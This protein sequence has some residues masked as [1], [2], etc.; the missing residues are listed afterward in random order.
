MTAHARLSAL[1]ASFLEAE[2]AR[3]PLHVGSISVFEPGGLLDE[4]GRVRLDDARAVIESRLSQ[5]PKLRQRVIEL[6]VGLGRPVWADDPDF[7]VADHV[8]ATTLPW[9]GSEAQLFE[10]A[11]HLHMQRLDRSRPLWEFWFVDGLEGDRVALVTKVHHAVIDGVSGAEALTVIL[12]PTPEVAPVSS[13]P[14]RPRPLPSAPELVEER[15]EELTRRP[16]EVLR[17]VEHL[18]R[19]PALLVE[20]IHELAEFVRGE[21]L[22]PSS[23]LNRTVGRRRRFVAVRASLHEAKEIRA[24]LGGS[25][26][27]VVLAAVATGLRSVLEARDEPVEQ[28]TLR[29]LVPM[30]IRQPEERL[31]LGNRVTA[32]SVPVPVHEPDPLVRLAM[33]QEAMVEAKASGEGEGAGLLLDLAETWPTPVLGAVSRYLVHNQPLVNVVVTNVPGPQTPLYALGA[34]ME[35]IL[36]VVP[37]GGN[38]TV[39]VGILSYDGQLAMG[40][41]ADADACP[42]LEQLGDAV[43]AGWAELRTLAGLGEG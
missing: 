41:Y 11:E 30:S 40:L 9:P 25:V 39:A 19:T 33:L 21:S 42:D 5:L 24:V 23:S 6:P 29:A 28:V 36:P 16:A 2:T 17:T 37:L 12:D 10:L 26:N 7:D 14:W 1:D 15:V 27:D 32:L 22:A 3:T 8:R 4:H 34:R 18:L 35:E 31:A 20:R 38:L 13:P 43:A